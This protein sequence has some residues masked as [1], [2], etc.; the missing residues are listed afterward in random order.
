MVEVRTKKFDIDNFPV[1]NQIIIYSNLLDELKN[2]WTNFQFKNIL[3]LRS[4]DVSSIIKANK[5]G[6]QEILIGKPNEYGVCD[7]FTKQ[8]VLFLS[9]LEVKP[10]T[11]IESI[12]NSIVNRYLQLIRKYPDL[13]PNHK[14]N[15]KRGKTHE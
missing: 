14:N 8:D 5:K 7:L 3:Q 2:N 4:T 10:T 13:D 11:T 6:Y 12:I 15:L 1:E 9:V